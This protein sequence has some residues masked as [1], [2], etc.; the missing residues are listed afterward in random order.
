MIA[1]FAIFVQQDNDIVDSKLGDL[2]LKLSASRYKVS[3]HLN[4]L[5]PSNKPDPEIALSI[6]LGSAC[7]LDVVQRVK[8]FKPVD[9]EFYHGAVSLYSPDDIKRVNSYDDG[10][11]DGLEVGK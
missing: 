3:N 6:A 7:N 11:S 5:D 10:S 1:P 2:I 8:V 4:Q 9:K